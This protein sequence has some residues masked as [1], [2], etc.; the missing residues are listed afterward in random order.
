MG[1][2]LREV[3]D[4]ELPLLFGRSRDGTT[5]PF[6]VLLDAAPP[7]PHMVWTSTRPATEPSF[8]HGSTS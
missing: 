3:R 6:R 2:T 8:S 5:V 7:V 4:E 1:L